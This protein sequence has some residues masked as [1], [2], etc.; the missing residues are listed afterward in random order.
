MARLLA[1]HLEHV[2]D[3]GDAGDR[4]LGENPAESDGAD[5]AAADIDGAAAHALQDAGLALDQHAVH[6]AGEDDVAADASLGDDAQDFE[7]KLLDVGAVEDGLADG[8]HAR[9]DLRHRHD[10]VLPHDRR[11]RLVGVGLGD[12][13][14][15]S[16]GERQTANDNHEDATHDFAHAMFPDIRPGVH[17]PLEGRACS[18]EHRRP[19]FAGIVAQL[20]RAKLPRLCHYPWC[21]R[22]QAYPP[23]AG[24]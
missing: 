12:D 15:T 19:A 6:D 4:F 7:M 18:M 22:A 23:A 8:G 10:L 16:R 11:H 2:L 1:Q 20:R 14:R 24:G 5:E 21:R 9:A 13:L 17:P 3:G